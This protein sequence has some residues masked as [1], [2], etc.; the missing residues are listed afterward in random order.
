MTELM[1]DL[2]YLTNDDSGE[3]HRNVLPATAAT[4]VYERIVPDIEALDFPDAGLCSPVRLAQYA[5]SELNYPYM[6]RRQLARD[7]GIAELAESRHVFHH[8]YGSIHLTPLT[9]G[10]IGMEIN[11]LLRAKGLIDDDLSLE[12]YGAMFQEA[13]FGDILN[14]TAMTRKSVVEPAAIAVLD[15]GSK[16]GFFGE[17]TGYEQNPYVISNDEE[18]GLYSVRLKKE[19]KVAL[20]AKIRPSDGS[21]CP[22]ARTSFPM[23]R[24][25]ADYLVENEFIGGKSGYYLSERTLASSGMVLACRPD[26]YTPI[27]DVVWSWGRYIQRYAAQLDDDRDLQNPVA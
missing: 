10:V 3:L 5:R 23:T 18:T 8:G 26:Q 2:T 22:V 6:E 20:R 14:D 7:T 13:W 27:D 11:A 1:P 24:K 17:A 4:H 15:K 21:G 9:A 25:Q 19:V 12:E 16:K